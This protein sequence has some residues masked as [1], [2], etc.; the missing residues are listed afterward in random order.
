MN[1]RNSC[2]KSGA[3]QKFAYESKSF[4]YEKWFH[5]AELPCATFP[6]YQFDSRISGKAVEKGKQIIG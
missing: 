6:L 2:A 5:T 3:P 4:A 1:P